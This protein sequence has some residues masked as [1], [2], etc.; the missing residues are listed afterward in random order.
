MWCIPKTQRN[1]KVKTKGGGQSTNGRADMCGGSNIRSQ[2]SPRTGDLNT[3]T[4]L[5]TPRAFLKK[6]KWRQG[7]S[8]G[9]PRK[10]RTKRGATQGGD[11][12]GLN[13]G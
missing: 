10:E 1:K 13:I 2:A 5:K 11:T 12:V 9:Y 3:R 4:A 8:W 7:S 6:R